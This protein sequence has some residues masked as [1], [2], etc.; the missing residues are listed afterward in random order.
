MTVTWHQEE[1]QT[2]HE[3]MLQTKDQ[4]TNDPVAQLR[5]FL[6]SKLMVTFFKEWNMCVVAGT[7]WKT[8]GIGLD[9]S[10]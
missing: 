3:H 4:R 5:L 2:N 1:K 7:V 8:F 6:L 9:K 10:G